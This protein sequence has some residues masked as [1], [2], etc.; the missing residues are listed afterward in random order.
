MKKLQFSLFL[1]LF[2]PSLLLAKT[3]LDSLFIILDKT[4]SERPIYNEEKEQR[5]NKLREELLTVSSSDESTYKILWTLFDEYRSYKM[6]MS[7]YYANEKMKIAERIGRQDYID[8]TKINLAEVMMIVGMYKEALEELQ[9]IDKS[10]LASYLHPYYY[11]IYYTTYTLMIDY[12]VTTDAKKTYTEKSNLYRDSLLLDLDPTST[13][14]ILF[15]TDLKTKGKDSTSLQ[16]LL[17][18]LIDRCR[19]TGPNKHDEALLAYT[20]AEIYQMMGDNENAKKY[21]AISAINDLR[22]SIKGHISLRKLAVLL[23][24]DE[25]ITRS[26][27]YLKCSMEDAIFCNARQRTIEISEVFPIVNKAYQ[28]KTQ[29]QQRQM[30]LS[31]ICISV[32]SIFLILIIIYVYKQMKHLAKARHKLR[33]VNEELKMLNNELE[34]TNLRLSKYNE[35]LSDTNYIKEEYIGRYMNLCS[36]YIEKTDNYRRSLVKLAIA[37]KV[38]ELFKS[39]KSV[40]FLDNE[41]KEFYTDFDNTFLKLFPTFIENFNQLLIESERITPKK[42]EYLTTELRVFAL[43]RLGITDTDRIASFLRS[44]KATIYSYRSRIRNKSFNPETFEKQVMEISSY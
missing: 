38:E 7:L 8:D 16:A 5:I 9:K 24:Q 35:A 37:G 34:T 22:F 42:E 2:F 36:V 15:E 30:L 32:L 3:K 17:P 4:I 13:R 31:L 43:I 33:T 20:I 11:D 21:Y 10:K 14:Y 28:L 1:F 27:N 39:I 26:Y 44:S 40:K 29:N 18:P 6:D 23:Y 25:D 12:A 41:L 19:K